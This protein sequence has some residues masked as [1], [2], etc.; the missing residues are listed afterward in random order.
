MNIIQIDPTNRHQVRQ[1]LDLPFRIYRRIPQWVP[2]L[3][4]DAQRLFDQRRHPFYKHS[5]AA[6]FVARDDQEEA[7]G[8]LAVLDNQR[9]NQFNREQTA[10]FYLFECESDFEVSRALFEAA[11]AWARQRGLSQ[12]TGPKGFTALDGMGL[13]VEGFEHRPA[14]G[15]PYNPSYYPSLIEAVGFEPSGDV[16][17]GYL[18]RAA[19]F[20][21]R[22][23]RVAER[24]RERRGLRVVRFRKRH[25]LRMLVPK[26]K[27]L[28][29]AALGDT[30]G[31]VPLTEDEARTIAN[32]L[33]WFADPR[34]IKIVMKGD[35]PVGFLFAYPDISGAVQRTKG[36]LFPWGWITLLLE[37]R[38]T[39]WVNINGAGI[40]SEYRGLGGT[41][42]LFS[43]MQK[44][45]LEGG[46]EHADLVQIGQDNARMQ[47]EL[48]GLGID[49][50]KRHRLYKRSL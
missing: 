34:L 18:N 11:F 6:F 17:S 29:N 27:D 1:F 30:V 25:D 48:E 20:P 7:I 19:Q 37:L 26:L 32:Q 4:S 28:Y 23:H 36:R 14:F 38:R 42:L 31:N 10:F 33:L 44:S 16:V 40:T 39:K 35:E 24:V 13:L 3:A 21:E 5:E 2:P 12:I 43:E 46:F 49:F 41:A 45:I 22:F 47:R 50:Y 8:R 15:I 9:Y